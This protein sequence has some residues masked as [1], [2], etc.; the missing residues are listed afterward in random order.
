LRGESGSTS[1]TPIPRTGTRSQISM[2]QVREVALFEGFL[3]VVPESGQVLC[4]S[5]IALSVI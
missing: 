1:N 5:L 2:S 4:V 3:E